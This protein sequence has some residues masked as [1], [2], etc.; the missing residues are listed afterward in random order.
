MTRARKSCIWHDICTKDIPS[1]PYTPLEMA[2]AEYEGRPFINSLI[3]LFSSLTGEESQDELNK[4]YSDEM[5][6]DYGLER[7]DK[8]EI[9]DF[10][11]TINNYN[12]QKHGAIIQDCSLEQVR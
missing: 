10:I 7:L 11:Y 3:W 8:A 6:S 1:L 5:L 9:R 4:R 2:L 12:A